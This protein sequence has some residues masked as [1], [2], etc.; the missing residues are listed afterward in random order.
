MNKRGDAGD[1]PDFI[2]FF[3]VLIIFGGGIVVSYFAFFGSDY[4]IKKEEARAMHDKLRGCL[5]DKANEVF[6]DEFSFKECGFSEKFFDNNILIYIKRESD[7]KEK[8]E[9]VRDFINQCELIDRFG[10]FP[11]CWKGEIVLSGEKYIIIGGSNQRA[12]D[13]AVN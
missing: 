11:K 8:F 12:R 9:G 1:W 4:D 5:L 10:R 7:G 6:A 2:G 13:V 3:L